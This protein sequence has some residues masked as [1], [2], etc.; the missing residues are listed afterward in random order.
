MRMR[1]VFRIY[2]VCHSSN[3]Y[4][5]HRIVSTLY[6]FKSLIVLV[7]IFDCTC[8]NLWTSMVKSWILKN[9]DRLEN[10]FFSYWNLGTQM[11]NG[12]FV[13]CFLETDCCKR[14]SSPYKH[15]TKVLA[16]GNSSPEEKHKATCFRTTEL[17]NHLPQCSQRALWQMVLQ[18]CSP[19][20]TW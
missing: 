15:K 9:W 11:G 3:F 4:T 6:L 14:S 18:L 8:S 20:T 19:K 5:Q 13:K 12:H 10:I 16:F 1:R 2:T 7:Q 17:Q